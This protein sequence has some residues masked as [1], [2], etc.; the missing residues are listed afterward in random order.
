MEQNI[1][2]SVYNVYVLYGLVVV[3]IADAH[4]GYPSLKPSTE[5][6]SY[7]W[8]NSHHPVIRSCASTAEST[9][10]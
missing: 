9:K 2:Y 6:F 8:V 3:K 5:T 1:K 10:Y 7:L 4:P